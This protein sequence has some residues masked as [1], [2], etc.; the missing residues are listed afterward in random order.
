MSPSPRFNPGSHVGSHSIRKFLGVGPLGERY[1]VFY[2]STNHL[3]CLT[4]PPEGAP[5]P[6]YAG[7]LRRA[8]PLLREPCV[9]HPFAAG[10]DG[11]VPWLRS[12]LPQ[13]AP[14]WTLSSPID[15]DLLP[16]S[17]RIE[18]TSRDGKRRYLLVPTVADLMRAAGTDFSP[19]DRDQILGDVFEGLA[20]LHGAGLACGRF[21]PS[22]IDL[23]RFAHTNRA[24]ASLRYYRD[25]GPDA[26]E[27]LAADLPLAAELVRTLAAACGRSRTNA[28]LRSFADALVS[29]AHPDAAAARDALVA[30]FRAN[31]SAYAPHRDPDA[32]PKRRFAPPD[33]E[34]A[35]DERGARDRRRAAGR[36]RGPTGLEL[37]SAGGEVAHRSV[38]LLR[39]LLMLLG[40]AGVGVG[41]FFFLKWND[42]R[43]R[44]AHAI[45]SAE[46]YNSVSV[47]PLSLTEAVG[48]ADAGLDGLFEMPRD[49]LEAE[50][51][52]GNA[53]AI[54][55]LAVEDVLEASDRRAAAAA[56]A[57]RIAPVLP[58]LAKA[59]GDDVSAAY[60]HGYATLLGIGAPA[61]PEAAFRELDDAAARG[62][63]RAALLLGD[64]FA[65]D[66][67][68]PGGRGGDRL[69]RDRDA[70]ARYRAAGGELSAPTP[71]WRAAADRVAAV[72]RR[73]ESAADFAD[74]WGSWLRAS[75]SSGHIP[76]MALLGGRGPFAP[77]APADSLEWLRRIN[78]YPGALPWVRAWAQ[79]RMAAMFA[80]G[81]GVPRSDS[82]ARLWYER[83]AQ[84]G[85]RTAMLAAAEFHATGRGRND[86]RPDPEAAAEWRRKAEDA[87]PEP[88]FDPVLLPIS[89]DD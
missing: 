46:T 87:G 31:G 67:P 80:E 55:R 12:E 21:E 47:I 84:A 79:V 81:A 40:I 83:A 11:G 71:L 88:D 33:P 30:L 57:A 82:S 68:L 51:G 69:A 16:K 44:R 58:A 6:D 2:G 27:A 74:D 14:E 22:E 24:V 53:L 48:G 66:R 70:L 5:A 13:G 32:A 43:E 15:P 73:A 61:D 17:D 89:L 72:L 34:S 26:A 86:G 36:R 45:V 10:E 52:A 37:V 39:G 42:E 8:A 18:A 19:K 23:D 64:W 76:S 75:A 62:S 28:A 7:F 63:A 1:E 9:G 41:V 54:A 25:P 85:N 65:S 49:L 50:A 59:A 29:G 4:V 77:A 60:L 3:H 78:N 35:E 20:A 38:Q 56:A